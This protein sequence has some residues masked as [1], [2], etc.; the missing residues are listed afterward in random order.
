MEKNIYLQPL[1]VNIITLLQ[2]TLKIK[3]ILQYYQPLEVN[4]IT[5]L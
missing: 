3:Y 4:I 5:L 1:E 2:L